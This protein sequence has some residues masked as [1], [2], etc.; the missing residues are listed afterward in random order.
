[1]MVF[2]IHGKK[3]FVLNQIM[4]IIHQLWFTAAGAFALP[5]ASLI[6]I[7]VSSIL[8]I[9]A[10]SA[11][12]HCT[13]YNE[14]FDGERCQPC[15]RA[16]C[17]I[18]LYRMTCNPS[19]TQDARC[20]YCS[21]PPPNAIHVT[22]G[23]PY[24][25]DNCM[26]VCK[27]GYYRVGNSC[28]ACNIEECHGSANMIRETC[29]RGATQDAQC[30]CLK[31]HFIAEDPS[32]EQNRAPMCIPCSVSNCTDPRTDTLV[33]CPGNTKHDVSRCIPNMAG[34]PPV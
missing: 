11:Q 19:S 2:K 24:T 30:V 9:P 32:D 16:P 20:T 14:F 31:D 4:P 15:T 29:A 18:G 27:E 1:M 13:G 33:Q 12:T 5:M 3:E 17:G 7:V 21:S 23:L 8:S 28:E 6:I 22:G 25:D 26:W 10:V 34:Q